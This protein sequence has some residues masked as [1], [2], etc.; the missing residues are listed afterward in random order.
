MMVYLQE[1]VNWID[2]ALIFF[3]R[4]P[5]V[6]IAGYFLGTFVLALCCVV[7]GQLTISVAFLANRRRIDADN[8][9]MVR[10][11]NL[12]IK[13][14]AAKNKGAYKA[15][16]KE[17]NEA[18]GKVFFMQ[19]ALAAASLW[20]VPFALAWMQTRFSEVEFPLPFALPMLGDTV[21]YTFSFFP[22][23]ILAF[24]LFGKVKRYLPYF[25][26]IHG[27]LDGYTKEKEDMITF[28]DLHPPRVRP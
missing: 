10:M 16:N 26:R 18:F 4:L 14:L 27:I 20:P 7:I 25:K 1:M 2:N 6:P 5:E 11:Q 28:A 9:N 19:I 17:A 21:G 22:I 23:L 24:M 15:F 13:A 12:S 3:Y 8:S